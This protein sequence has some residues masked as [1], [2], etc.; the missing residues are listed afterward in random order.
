M[1]YIEIFDS[2]DQRTIRTIIVDNIERRRHALS[3]PMH[4][5]ERSFRQS[6]INNNEKT[7]LYI[8][9]LHRL[10]DRQMQ[11]QLRAFEIRLNVVAITIVRLETLH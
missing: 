5:I 11:S 2:P 3:T 9:A 7:L 6:I 4:N 8:P 1:F 10:I